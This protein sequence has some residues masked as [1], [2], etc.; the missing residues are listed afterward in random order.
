MSQAI[1]ASG[2][3][4][5]AERP[6]WADL[7]LL[8]RTRLPLWLPVFMGV[9]VITYFAL[10]SEPWWW[11]GG[12]ATAACLPCALLAKPWPMLRAASLPFLAAAAGFAS[13]QF[14]TARA[15]L[16]RCCRKPPWF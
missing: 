6:W 13:A 1:A 11:L 14:A 4:W 7:L 2:E 3:V 16:W 5:T 10:R 15:R 12:A 9:G 8:E